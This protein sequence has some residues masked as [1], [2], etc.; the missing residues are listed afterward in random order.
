MVRIQLLKEDYL[1]IRNIEVVGVKSNTCVNY[2]TISNE[3]ET[4]KGV[5]GTFFG[6]KQI[7]TS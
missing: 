1:H 6:R 7:F 2:Q 3:L 4:M 5:G